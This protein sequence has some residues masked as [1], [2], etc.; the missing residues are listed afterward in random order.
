MVAVAGLFPK[1]LKQVPRELQGEYLL[2]IKI[3]PDKTQQV[4]TNLPLFATISSNRI[5]LDAGASRSVERVIQVTQKG[6]NVYLVSFA[7][8]SSWIITPAGSPDQLVVLEP[9]K[10]N[11]KSATMLVISRDLTNDFPSKKPSVP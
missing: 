1:F 8:Q 4:F 2:K 9:T 11:S 3:N 7:D 6:T 5:T 10:T